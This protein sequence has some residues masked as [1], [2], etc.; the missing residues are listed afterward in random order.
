M[1]EISFL[2]HCC[3]TR[4]DTNELTV[5]N[6]GK[7]LHDSHLFT[8]NE[9]LLKNNYIFIHCVILLVLDCESTA[10]DRELNRLRQDR[11]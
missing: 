7:Q 8:G 3:V 9:L 11:P 5:V 1:R 6:D 2:L 10:F 4:L